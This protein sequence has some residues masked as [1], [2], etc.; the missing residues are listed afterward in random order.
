MRDSRDGGRVGG[1]RGLIA[2]TV[3]MGVLILIGTAV[4]V[5]VIVERASAPAAK[6][7]VPFAVILDEPAGTRITGVT[8][9][10]GRMV[11]ELQGGGPDRM[12]VMDPETGTVVG[13]VGLSR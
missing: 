6:A 5:V 8:A 4:L 2:L 7:P 10:G 12:V 9:A 1:M 3:G 11:V 13:R